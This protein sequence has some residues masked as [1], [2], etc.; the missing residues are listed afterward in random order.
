MKKEK[1]SNTMAMIEVN[2]ENYEQEVLNS[3]LPVLIDF[4]ADWCGPCQ[5]LK[6]VIHELAEELDAVK[7]VSV[8]VDDVPELAEEFEVFS[9]PCLVLVKDGKE[10]DRRIGSAPKHVLEGWLKG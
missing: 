6:P 4:N 7:F 3:D 10:A 8:N 5:M 1:E 9:I 2:N